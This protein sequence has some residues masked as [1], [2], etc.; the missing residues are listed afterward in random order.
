M[1]KNLF[2]EDLWDEWLDTPVKNKNH[3]DLECTGLFLGMLRNNND[4]FSIKTNR[5]RIGRRFFGK[6]K[7]WEKSNLLKS[8]WNIK[9]SFCNYKNRKPFI[10]FEFLNNNSLNDLFFLSEKLNLK[11]PW[12]FLRGLWGASGGL[13]FPKNGYSL[14]LIISNPDSRKFSENIISKTKLSWIKRRNEFNLR[15]HDDIV[16]FLNNIGL[17]TSALRL[18]DI[19]IFKSIRNQINRTQNYETANITRSIKASLEQTRLAKKIIDEN[20]ID[21]LPEKLKNLVIAR[22]N[23]PE[24]SLS[25]LGEN[26][27]PKIKKSA[28]KYRWLCLVKFLRNLDLII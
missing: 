4:N 1:N 14:S 8:N 27:N 15:N 21:S 20:L 13:Y 11:N 10:K 2:L 23:N 18:E 17:V 7:L 25:E 24:A 16:T 26:L 5:L 3:A 6:N 12:P 9:F 28:V 19:A 22:L